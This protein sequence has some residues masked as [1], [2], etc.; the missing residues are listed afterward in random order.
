MDTEYVYLGHDNRIDLQLRAS[1]AAYSAASV[2]K[3]S[4]TFGSTK[5]ENS[6]AASGAITWSGSSW[7]TGE[8][9]FKLGDQSISTGIYNA[10][11]VVYTA[12]SS[13]GIVWDYV[14]VEVKADPEG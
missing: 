7:S 10:P 11:V 12:V 4:I 1:S 8:V 2:T 13:A 9:R 5:I 14:P 3:I 6:S